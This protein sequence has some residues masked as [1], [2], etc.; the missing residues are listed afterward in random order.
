MRLATVSFFRKLGHSAARCIAETWYRQ[1]PSSDHTGVTAFDSMISASYHTHHT[2]G[3]E[4]WTPNKGTGASRL[5]SNTVAMK[6]QKLPKEVLDIPGMWCVVMAEVW[7]MVWGFSSNP[8]EVKT[9]ALLKWE[10]VFFFNWIATH[11]APSLVFIQ[12]SKPIQ[13]KVALCSLGQE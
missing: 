3:I 11:K 12:S 10:H 8:C 1:Y 2:Q 4:Y 7:R 5:A 6:T 9:R 13:R